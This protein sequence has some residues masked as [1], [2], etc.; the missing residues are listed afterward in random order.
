MN[1]LDASVATTDKKHGS[2]NFPSAC[3]FADSSSRETEDNADIRDLFTAVFAQPTKVLVP[4]FR[5]QISFCLQL[6]SWWMEMEAKL[7]K[8]SGHFLLYMISLGCFRACVHRVWFDH[9]TN[10]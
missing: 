5:L 7:A 6:T 10:A 2:K 1:E 8:K 3:P 9:G 4:V